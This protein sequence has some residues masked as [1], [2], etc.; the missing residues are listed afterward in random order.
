LALV[1][2]PSSFSDRL[3]LLALEQQEVTIETIHHGHQN[4]VP[5]EGSVLVAKVMESGLPQAE[6]A[7]GAAD[8]GRD[9][10]HH[11]PCL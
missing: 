9:M 7:A 3:P 11:W 10:G 6:A 1:I 4:T 2:F 8:Y 5:S